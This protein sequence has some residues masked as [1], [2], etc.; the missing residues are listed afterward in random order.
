MLLEFSVSGPFEGMTLREVWLN[1]WLGKGP[2]LAIWLLEVLR[3]LVWRVS[4]FSRTWLLT[5]PPFSGFG[6]L[7]LLEF[8]LHGKQYYGKLAS[9]EVE[10]KRSCQLRFW[11]SRVVAFLRSRYHGNPLFWGLCF[12]ESLEQ[13]FSVFGT[14]SFWQNPF[15][16]IRKLLF[17]AAN[18]FGFGNTKSN[19]YNIGPKLQY[20]YSM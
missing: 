7:A 5:N 2:F 4:T 15:L 16:A 11:A 3:K 17:L 8:W 6:I 12:S 9:R 18:G 10:F 13:Y 19:V 14:F 20:K 1:S